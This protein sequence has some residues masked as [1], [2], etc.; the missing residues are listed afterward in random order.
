[1]LCKRD[2]FV[3]MPGIESR[4]P[5]WLVRNLVTVLTELSHHAE[6]TD[7]LS[8]LGRQL[9]CALCNGRVKVTLPRPH[10]FRV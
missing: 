7:T 10:P 4:F 3:T 5:D 1:M 6:D 2:T 9:N 8:S